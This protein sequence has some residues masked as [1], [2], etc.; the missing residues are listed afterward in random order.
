MGKQ[1]KVKWVKDKAK[2]FINPYNF[3]SKTKSV[4]RTPLRSGNRSGSVKCRIIVKDK[5]ALPDIASN[6]NEGSQTFDFYSINGVPVIPGSELRGCIRSVFEAVTESCFSVVNSTLLSKRISK[7]DNNRVPGVLVREKNE[8]IIYEAKYREGKRKLK[9]YE[10]GNH[11][12]IVRKWIKKGNKP[13]VAYSYFFIRRE[14]GTLF[15]DNE[16]K[17]S[18]A[19]CTDNDVQKFLAILDSYEIGIKDSIKKT[20]RKINSNSL[21]EL[22]D[23]ISTMKNYLLI[24]KNSESSEIMLPIFYQC[25]DTGKLQYFSPAHT[26]RQSFENTVT[27]LLGD[28]TPC[29]GDNGYCPACLLFGTLGNNKPIASRLRFTDATPTNSNS[30]SLSEKPII[31]P[32]LSSPKISSIEF[33]SNKGLYGDDVNSWDY[34]DNS[35]QLNGRK[36][37]FHSKAKAAKELGKRQIETITAN[38]GSEFE[39]EVFFDLIHDDEIKMLLWVLTLGDNFE[40]SNQLHKLGTGRPVGF[41]S[42]KILVDEVRFREFD[43]GSFNYEVTTREYLEYMSDFSSE[44]AFDIKALRDILTI[45]NYYLLIDEKSEEDI[46]RVSYPIAEK[47]PTPNKKESKENLTAGHQWFTSNRHHNKFR[48]VLPKLNES[49]EELKLYSMIGTT[50]ETNQSKKRF[51]ASMFQIGKR[52]EA[53][54]IGYYIR[55][56]NT[57]VKIRVL[58]EETTILAK[59]LPLQIKSN[60]EDA[61]RNK[62]NIL[63]VFMGVNDKSIPKFKV[64]KYLPR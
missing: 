24:M 23:I 21:T 26:G 34:D 7:P 16:Y 56:N 17:K 10:N 47:K 55:N 49:I 1:T 40:N 29:G 39:F 61:I 18:P 31:I 9:E 57:I 33:Y 4:N 19:V 64:E 48:N 60:V 2:P 43:Y 3:V 14:K 36:F 32:E 59:W 58:G 37:Y 41:G 12:D 46:I 5:L 50:V 11:C 25:D 53:E 35:I 52:Y 45:T 62:M 13:E 27:D 6:T 8:W 51:N 22:K 54:L 42:V 30:V 38:S 15:A 63:V 20:A 28:H 44:N